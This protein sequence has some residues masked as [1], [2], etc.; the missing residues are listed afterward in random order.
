MGW[1]ERWRR[2]RAEAPGAP[3]G[4]GAAP[5]PA[6]EGA[7]PRGL[8]GWVEA[9]AEKVV[10]KAYEIHA[11]DLEERARRVVSSVYEKTADDLEERAV[12]AMR[13]ALEA[14][15]GRI[16]EAIEHGVAVKRREVRWS[17]LVLIVSSLV[18][19]ALHWLTTR[20]DGP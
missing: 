20:P 1:L 4:E 3:E 14:E 5:P 7:E 6:G 9:R 16:K 17:L 18:Y 12:R 13:R 15:A 19:L 8:S 2:A 10:K 11:E